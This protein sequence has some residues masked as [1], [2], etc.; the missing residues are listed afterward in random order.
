VSS[1]LLVAVSSDLVGEADGW[2]C[3]YSG[4]LSIS[5]SKVIIPL[6]SLIYVILNT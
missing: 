1:V 5:A 2:F 3:A 4:A 6:L